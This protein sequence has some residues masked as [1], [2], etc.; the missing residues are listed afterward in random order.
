MGTGLEGG[1]RGGDGKERDRVSSLS[2]SFLL[3][4]GKKEMVGGGLLSWTI[5]TP[6]R[7][8][9]VGETHGLLRYIGT[10]GSV[11]E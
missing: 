7:K 3:A 10:G 2:F 9:G 1:R 11:N 6:D 4:Q 8:H 5:D